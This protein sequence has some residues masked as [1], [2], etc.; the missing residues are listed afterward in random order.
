MRTRAEEKH[1][2]TVRTAYTYLIQHCTCHSSLRYTEYA[3]PRRYSTTK[4]GTLG[5]PLGLHYS[6][7]LYNHLYTLALSLGLVLELLPLGLVLE[8]LVHLIVSLYTLALSV[9][10]VCRLI[11]M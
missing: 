4:G 3:N 7:I 10:C 11:C 6:Q 8:L 9:Y 2:H 1:H 5:S